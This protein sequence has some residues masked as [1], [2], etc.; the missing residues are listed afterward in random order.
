YL[1][2]SPQ[3]R[4]ALSSSTI[5]SD[6]HRHFGPASAPL[7]TE[8]SQEPQHAPLFSRGP[9][10]IPKEVPK[11][12]GAPQKA[13]SARTPLSRS[14]PQSRTSRFFSAAIVLVQ[15]F[16]AG[17]TANAQAAPSAGECYRV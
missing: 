9:Q 17:V 11:R 2:P 3:K 6:L 16:G 15:L 5:T 8:T 7:P 12:G 4:Q 13:L 1:L 10:E 14:M